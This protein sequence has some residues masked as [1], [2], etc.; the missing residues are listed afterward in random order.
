MAEAGI[1]RRSAVAGVSALFFG[2]AAAG[3]APLANHRHQ[4]TSSAEKEQKAFKFLALTAFV[5]VDSDD[6]NGSVAVMRMFV[7]PGAGAAPHV[8]SREDEIFTIVRGHYRMR[9]G[10]EEVDA[11]AG[12]IIFMPRGVPH[13]FRNVSDEPGEHVL[14]LVPGGLEKM[15][16]EVSAAQIEMPR[17]KTKYDEIVAKYGMRNLPP[18]S[19]PFSTG[20]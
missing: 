18:D 3:Q 10:D 7:P 17:D 12:S 2:S 20:G 16:R 4:A 6:T 13:T 15:F 9:H 1:T 8:H 14:T 5:E 19:L 11:P